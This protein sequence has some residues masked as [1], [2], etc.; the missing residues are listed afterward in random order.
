MFT[1]KSLSYSCVTSLS[2]QCSHYS[3]TGFVFCLA[4]NGS[5][6]CIMCL[7]I[8]P[9]NLLMEI[10][11]GECLSLDIKSKRLR[12]INA[13]AT[14]LCF[15]IVCVSDK[16]LDAFLA[17]LQRE[18]YVISRTSKNQVTQHISSN[19]QFRGCVSHCGQTSFLVKKILL[20]EI[21][22]YRVIN[23]YFLLQI[24][25]VCVHLITKFSCLFTFPIQNS[26]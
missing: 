18:M 20:Y 26:T 24:S 6:L 22:K 1:W 4:M 23:T 9:S 3:T 14:Q 2:S 25:A 5:M 19:N 17:Y 21:N 12:E 13:Y 7:I 10:L 8:R 16:I 11:R 15:V